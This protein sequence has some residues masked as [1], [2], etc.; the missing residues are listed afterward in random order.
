MA[1]T[2]AVNLN[3]ASRSHARPGH[4]APGARPQQEQRSR[5]PRQSVNISE[6][7]LLRLAR[8]RLSRAVGSK[9]SYNSSGAFETEAR[10]GSLLETRA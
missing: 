4:V 1:F 3:N 6:E 10:V 5:S 8:Q 2:D 9:L 7:T